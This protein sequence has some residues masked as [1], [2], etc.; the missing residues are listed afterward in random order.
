MGYKYFY[1]GGAKKLNLVVRGRSG[2]AAGKILVGQSLDALSC[3]SIPVQID[4]KDGKNWITIGGEM[5]F[6]EGTYPLYLKFE[7][8]GS[9]DFAQFELA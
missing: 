8:S 4:E 3:G 2:K 6:K 1:F 5:Q 9:F 7:G